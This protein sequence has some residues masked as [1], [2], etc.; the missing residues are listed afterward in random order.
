MCNIHQ[1]L[2]HNVKRIKADHMSCNNN[3]EHAAAKS[4]SRGTTFQLFPMNIHLVNIHIES[5]GTFFYSFSTFAFCTCICMCKKLQ[6]SSHNVTHNVNKELHPIEFIHSPKA[7]K[8]TIEIS[9]SSGRHV[10]IFHMKI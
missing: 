7:P 2:N 9:G 5:F 8:E 10:V 1:N 3:P 4:C 6:K